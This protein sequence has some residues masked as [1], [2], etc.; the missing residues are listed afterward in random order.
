MAPE[1][2][3]F[4]NEAG[5]FRDV[6]ADVGGP[7][8]QETSSRGVAFGDYDDDGDQDIFIVNMDEARAF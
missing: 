4:R 6:T 5:R 7:L 8:L 2:Q 3:L 1:K